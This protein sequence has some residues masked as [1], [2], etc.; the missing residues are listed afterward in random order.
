MNNKVTGKTKPDWNPQ[1]AQINADA[2]PINHEYAKNLFIR[3]SGNEEGRKEER[4]N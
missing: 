3:K 1:I 2:N 4:R